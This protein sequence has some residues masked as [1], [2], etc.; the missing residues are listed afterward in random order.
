MTATTCVL[1]TLGKNKSLFY[2]T[3]INVYHHY[4]YSLHFL[5]FVLNI[6][7]CIHSSIH[8]FMH[9]SSST[10]SIPTSSTSKIKN[11]IYS[12]PLNAFGYLPP[13]HSIKHML[14]AKAM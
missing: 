9:H 2:F 11:H 7:A 8:P 6:Y 10:S 4:L 1:E 5:P 13:P 3:Y 14:K 12:S